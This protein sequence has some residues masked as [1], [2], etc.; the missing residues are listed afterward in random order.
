MP[1]GPDITVAQLEECIESARFWAGNLSS[2][3][4][5]MQ[6]LADRYTI[7]ASLI[8]TITGLGVWGTIAASTKWWG[9]GA[10]S[11]MA[12]AAAGAAVIPKVRGYSECALNAAPLAT[13]Y[14]KVLGI[15]EGALSELQ[16]GNPNAQT[17]SRDAIGKFDDVRAKK[18]V[19]KPCPN[20]I[21]LMQ[22][23]AKRG[24]SAVSGK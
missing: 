18:N 1:D 14:G 5:T 15:L 23:A 6:G 13:E 4:D 3:A 10:V 17:H 22:Q 8:S 16:S 12:F 21:V 2:Y 24:A 11:I 7:A 20:K 9:Q 19:L